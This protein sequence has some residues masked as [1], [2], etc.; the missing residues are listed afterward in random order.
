M[1]NTKQITIYLTFCLSVLLG[2]FFGENSSGGSLIDHR[3]TLP[4]IENFSLDIENGFKVYLSQNLTLIHSPSFY[5]LAGFFLRI[6]QNILLVK[7]IYII[8]S[9]FIPYIFYLII[10]EKFKIKKDYIF[11][12]SLLIFLSPYFRSS[13]IWLLGDNLSLLF[14]SLSVLFFAKINTQKNKVLNYYLCFFFLILCSYIRYYYCIFSIYYLIY[15]YKNLS[16]KNFFFISIFSFLLSTPAFFYLYIIIN[17]FN[18]LGTVSNFGSLNYYSNTLMIL[19]IILFY[20]LPFILKSSYLIFK[21]Y[22]N[23]Y[24]SFLFIFSIILIIYLIDLI[25]PVNLIF[26]SSKGGGV[27]VK[28]SN[29]FGIDTSLFLSVIAFISLIVL[30]YLFK[31]NRLENYILLSILICC[32][33]FTVIYQKYLDPLFYFIFFGLVNCTHI[34]NLFLNETVELILIY[35]YFSSFFLFSLIYYYEG[36]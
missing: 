17:K 26:F 6:T 13:A 8:I 22:K 2:L 27:F 25:F 9:C 19:S 33:P 32:F 18:F 21:F 1:L 31:D 5:V 15:F 36:A 11:Y 30:D 3:Y 34:K 23:K 14:F 16:Y 29:L 7:I 28:L 24:K 12:F 20:L 10:K 35:L 4:A